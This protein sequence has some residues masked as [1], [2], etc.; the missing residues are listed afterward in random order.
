MQR[1]IALFGVV[2]VAVTALA[3]ALVAQRGDAQVGT[4]E[5][6][7]AAIWTDKS[8]YN[9]GDPIQYCYRIPIAGMVTITDF[10]A[11][12]TSRV[13]FSQVVNNTQG[14]LE[15]TIT[16][17]PGHEC[18]RLTYPLFGGQGQTRTCFTVIGSVP[19]I[20]PLAIYVNP[21]QAVYTVG[22]AVDVCY[23]VPAPGPIRIIDQVNEDTPTTF[24]S[25]Y[26]DGTGGCIPGTVTPPT[27]REC[28]SIVFTYTADG[29]QVNA[30]T[31]FQTAP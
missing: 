23:R 24:F 28:M 21:P 1:R 4:V 17:P 10:P 13:I 19:P 5:P 26:D 14:C 12:G 27:G 9:I 8:S 6:G 16:P 7:T 20:N 18:L 25:G 29:R 11:D 3:A 2:F 15:G 30:Q 22:Q 31:C